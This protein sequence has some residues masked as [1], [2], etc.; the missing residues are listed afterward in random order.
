MV[1]SSSQG[2]WK[3]KDVGWNVFDL[4]QDKMVKRSSLAPGY[5]ELNA[6]QQEISSNSKPESVFEET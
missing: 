3:Q 6:T 5:F 4:K 1:S 2:N